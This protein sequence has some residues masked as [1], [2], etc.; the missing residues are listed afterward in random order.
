MTSTV[1]KVPAV[2]RIMLNMQFLAFAGLLASSLLAPI[3]AA[4]LEAQVET[5]DF[6]GTHWVD[7]WTSM[8][9]LTEP[10]NLPNPPFNQTG[11]VF[12][13]STIRQTLHMSIGGPQIRIRLSNVFGAT[14][15]NITAVTVALPFNNSAGQSIIETNTLQ[16]VTFSGNNSIIIPDGS[17][18]VSDPIHFPI[19]AQSELA[20]SIYLAGGQLGNSITSHPGSRTNSFYQFGNAVNAANLTDPS[21]QT[22][23]H[24]YFLSAVEVWSPPQ[25]RGFAI[26]GDSITDGR[27]STTNANNRWPDLVLARMQ[28]NPSTKD[29]GVLNQAAGGNR[30]LADGLGPNAIGRIDRDVL[31]QSG[32]KYSMIFEGVN[33]I[34]TAPSDAASQDFVYNQLI[35]AFEQIITRVHTFGIPIFGA[36]ITPFSGNVTIQAYSTPE[37]EVTRQRVNQWIRTSGKFDAVLDFDKVLRSPTNQSML[38]TQFD[39]GDFLHPNPAGYQAIADSFDLN[40]FNR[41]AGGVSS[42][43]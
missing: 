20:V 31:A 18:A 10:A 11:S 33:D 36:T 12:V 38:A 9:Q 3:N 21:V 40:L 42:Y 39:S 35:Q 23:A 17:L 5:R 27:G 25:A 26:V 8:P 1:V 43:M 15:L 32:I 28:K 16:T 13:N 4:P 41:F 2:S 22:V 24:W 30:I 6:G 19:K 37:R 14:Q 7:T 29:I 34:G